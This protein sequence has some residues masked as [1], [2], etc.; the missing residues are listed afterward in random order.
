MLIH[1]VDYAPFLTQ[2]IHLFHYADL[3]HVYQ[4]LFSQNKLTKFFF[5]SCPL[6]ILPCAVLNAVLILC[7]NHIKICWFEKYYYLCV[8]ITQYGRELRI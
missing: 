7:K 3:E 5:I 2:G 1:R 4:I 6:N 8:K